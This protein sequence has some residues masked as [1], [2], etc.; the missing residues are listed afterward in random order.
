MTQPRSN[1]VSLDATPGTRPSPAISGAYPC[2]AT[3]LRPRRAL[4]PSRILF[5]GF[6]NT[7]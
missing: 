6:C 3:T 5:D 1:L 2:G 7:E 4:H